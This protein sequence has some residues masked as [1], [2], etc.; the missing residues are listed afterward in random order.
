MA[1]E[2]YENAFL[3]IDGID[4]SAYLREVAVDYGSETQ[5]KTAM[6][7]DTRV[8]I[9]GLYTWGIS[10]TLNQDF[11]SGGPDPTLFSKVGKDVSVVF[12]P[13]AGSV[14]SSN[15]EYTGT[16][17]LDSAPPVGG[18]VGDMLTTS[19]NLVAASSLSRATS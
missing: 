12:R 5:D 10:A 4:L 16:A 3:S 17:V 1:V 18:S 15:P 8:S 6:P 2:I 19:I 9:G 7:D 13:D 14:G 11:A